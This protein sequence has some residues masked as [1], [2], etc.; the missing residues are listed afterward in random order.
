MKKT[1]L[2]F[3][4][5]PDDEVLGCGATI[6]RHIR[7]GDDVHVV[8]MAEGITSRP[9]DASGQ[10][11][12]LAR[13]HAAARQANA[14]LGATSLHLLGFADNRMDAVALLDVV[15]AVEGFIDRYRPDTV[16]TH[17]GGDVNIDHS[18][19]HRAVI[20]ACRPLPGQPVKTLLFFEVP[21]STEWQTPSS[22]APD[23]FVDVSVTLDAKLAALAAY[24]QELRPFPHPRSAEGV[25]HLAGWRGATVG[26]AAAEAFKVGRVIIA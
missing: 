21:S 15:K 8:I 25:R 16:Y 3:A 23:W 12:E 7:S 10:T 11:E 5:H 19:V 22:F 2:V 9:G 13:L 26:V 24:A 20:T 17:H 6:A 1:V 14:A 18:V 4:A